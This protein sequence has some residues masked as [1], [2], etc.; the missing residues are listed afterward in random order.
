MA[1]IMSR[2]KRNGSFTNRLL[3]LAQNPLIPAVP[4]DLAAQR[5]RSW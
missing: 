4:F 1:D 2:G 5:D 3:P